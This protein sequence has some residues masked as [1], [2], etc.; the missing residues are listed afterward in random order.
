MSGAIDLQDLFDY[1]D[2]DDDDEDDNGVYVCSRL[3]RLQ[4]DDCRNC[5][6]VC[7]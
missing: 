4:I 5:V 1:D 2:D 6:G 3:S 7:S